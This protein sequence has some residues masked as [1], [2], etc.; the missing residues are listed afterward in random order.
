VK[1]KAMRA[2]RVSAVTRVA[3]TNHQIISSPSMQKPLPEIT[4]PV[5]VSF[6][7]EDEIAGMAIGPV[8]VTA[9]EPY[10]TWLKA[11]GIPHVNGRGETRYSYPFGSKPEGR[12]DLGWNT[13]LVA[14]EVAAHYGVA[15]EEF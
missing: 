7:H 9:V 6:K 14:R 11:H 8:I 1:K 12:H 3:G 4:G 13:K 5:T 10:E 15:L 2:M